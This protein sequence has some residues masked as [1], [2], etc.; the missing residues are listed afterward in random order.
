MPLKVR[1][2]PALSCEPSPSRDARLVSFNALLNGAGIRATELV[3]L[4]AAPIVGE[5]RKPPRSS[6]RQTPA[7][8]PIRVTQHLCDVELVLTIIYI[9]PNPINEDGDLRRVLLHPI[10]QAKFKR[11]R[12]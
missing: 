11:Q 7:L 8:V 1:I 6:L 3:R 12:D 4:G 5:G 2:T 10:D 9:G